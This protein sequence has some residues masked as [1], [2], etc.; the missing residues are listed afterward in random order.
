[1]LFINLYFRFINCPLKN[2]VIPS[3]MTSQVAGVVAALK[4]K[5]FLL[6][7]HLKNLNVAHYHWELK[8]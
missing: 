4:R 2:S 1:M 8:D 3:N 7:G 5:S 6:N